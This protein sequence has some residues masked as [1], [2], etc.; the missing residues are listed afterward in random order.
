MSRTPETISVVIPALNEADHIPATLASLGADP[1]VQ[2]ILVDGGS[3]DGTAALARAHRATVLTSPPGRARQQNLGA[4]ASGKILFFL[5]ADTLAPPHYASLIRQTLCIPGV[6][7]G[8][9]S[10]DIAAPQPS[11][12]LI[13]A[14]ANCR[15]RWLQLPYGDQG[16]FL[17]TSLFHTLGGFPDV[18]IMEDLLLVRRLR[19]VGRIVI[20]PQG[21]RT[22]PRRWLQLGALRTT[23]INQLMLLGACW[24]IAPTTLA[25][26]YRRRT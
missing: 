1:A 22:S 12:K 7:A 26:L 17:S 21:V 15:S 4:A 9:F 6:A 13:S 18:P 20:L 25:R 23:A 14:L 3:Q 11:L 10:L 16:L 19:R 8:A 5:H 2:I 24:G